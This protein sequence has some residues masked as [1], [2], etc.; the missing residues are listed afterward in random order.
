VLPMSCA[1]SDMHVSC[2][3][4]SRP[5]QQRPWARNCMPSQEALKVQ[6]GVVLE[7]TCLCWRHPMDASGA[8]VLSYRRRSL[9]V[10]EP[11]TMTG[12][13][14]KRKRGFIKSYK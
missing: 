11:G 4:Q 3:F 6:G 2:S 9:C 5:W 12:K 10:H 1:C 14:R 13:R 8:A 7:V